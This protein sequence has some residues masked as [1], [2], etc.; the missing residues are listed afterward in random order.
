MAKMTDPLNSNIEYPKNYLG[1]ISLC[2]AGGGFILLEALLKLNII[3]GAGWQ[4]LAFGFEAGLAGAVADWFAV[5]ALF[6]EIPIPFMRKHTNIIIKKRAELTN[7]IVDMVQNRWLSPKA[8]EEYL[9]NSS[10]TAKIME[11]LESPEGE[12]NILAMIREMLAKLVEEIDRPEIAALLEKALKDQL[13]TLDIGEALGTWL[14]ARMQEGYQYKIWE[15]LL[16]SAERTLGD[17]I[18][19]KT[20]TEKLKEIAQKYSQQDMMKRF[21][22]WMAHKTGA[23]DYDKFADLIVERLQEVVA[24]AKNNPSHPL[25][26]E[27]DRIIFDFAEGLAKNRPDCVRLVEHF[28]ITL[29]KNTDFRNLLQAILQQLKSTLRQ[30]LAQNDSEM[31]TYIA[32]SLRKVLQDEPTRKRIDTWLR[33]NVPAFINK[34]HD[35]IGKIVRSSLD[36]KKL[37]NDT[38]IHEIEDKIGSDLQYIRLNGAVVGGC[39]GLIIG[40]LRYWIG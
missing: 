30:Q 22:L 29:L 10:V 40:I 14:M 13:Q 11:H 37:D 1:T 24:Q 35:E 17:A 25:R 31:M 9:S 3:S 19:R 38:L 39:V 4:I 20:V 18:I 7:G 36:P 32:N 12:Q 6:R 26:S 28:H 33:E 23:I 8:I 34:Y 2:I 27:L 16:S 21:W 5:K 15:T